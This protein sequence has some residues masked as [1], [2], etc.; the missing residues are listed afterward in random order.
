MTPA[1]V[2]APQGFQGLGGP[3]RFGSDNR[4]QAPLEVF[5]VTPDGPSPLLPPEAVAAQPTS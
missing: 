1:F 2:Q 5:E 3:V 4:M